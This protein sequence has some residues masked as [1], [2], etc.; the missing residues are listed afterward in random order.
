MFV[1]IHFP[2]VIDGLGKIAAGQIIALKRS[3]AVPLIAA[4]K[5]TPDPELDA[6]K[7]RAR[8]Q[9]QNVDWAEQ[10]PFKAMRPRAIV[11]TAATDE[12]FADKNQARYCYSTSTGAD[13]QATRRTSRER[14]QSLSPSHTPPSLKERMM[15]RTARTVRR[16]R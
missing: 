16:L 7:R 2:T 9:G 10:E 12:S 13:A 1:R 5:A 8:E 3:E 15:H 6:L 11:T 14:T 4:G